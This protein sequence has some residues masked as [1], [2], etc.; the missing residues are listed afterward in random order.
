MPVKSQIDIGVDFAEF[1]A[2]KTA[3]DKY[4]AAL[5]RCLPHGRMLGGGVLLLKEQKKCLTHLF[6]LPPICNK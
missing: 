1:L 3:F 6:A 2:L 4:E 5:K